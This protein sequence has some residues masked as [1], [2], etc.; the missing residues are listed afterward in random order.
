MCK[1]RDYTCVERESI[2]FILQIIL[3]T[4]DIYIADY[5]RFCDPE[6]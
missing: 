4:T 5:I 6:F 3:K 1:N 2:L